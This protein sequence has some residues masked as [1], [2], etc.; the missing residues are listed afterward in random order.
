MLA[1]GLLLALVTATSSYKIRRSECWVE[2]GEGEA[3]TTMVCTCGGIGD[4]YSIIMN[5][6]ETSKYKYKI[7][8]ACTQCRV[9]SPSWACPGTGRGTGTT[10][11]SR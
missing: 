5:K 3:S 8:N 7:L 4:P 10:W 2:E 9:L 1:R 11:R 6:V